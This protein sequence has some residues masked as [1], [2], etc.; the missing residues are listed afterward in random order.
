[1]KRK[2]FFLLVGLATLLAVGGLLAA[3]VAGGLFL[4]KSDAEAVPSKPRAASPT[5][6][7]EPQPLVGK[8]SPTEAPTVIGPSERAVDKDVMQW[9][10]KNLGGDKLKD[11]TKGRPYKVNVYQDSGKSAMNRAKVDLN[12]NDKWDEKWTFDGPN[13]TRQIAPADDENYSETY[14]WNGSAWAKQ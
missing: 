3:G 9:A 11:V 7:A 1:M 4:A 5:P 10:G 13:I 8:Q 2:H 12:R 6:Y 14:I